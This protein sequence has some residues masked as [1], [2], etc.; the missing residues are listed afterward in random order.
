MV[1][2]FSFTEVT[3]PEDKLQI[4]SVSQH[5][6]SHL[7]SPT[8]LENGLFLNNVEKEVKFVNFKNNI[9]CDLTKIIREKNKT[10]LKIFKIESS[11]HLSESLT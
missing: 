5:I 1:N 8:V 4:Y 7:Q 2:D 10:E 3:S 9:I 6:A 11:K